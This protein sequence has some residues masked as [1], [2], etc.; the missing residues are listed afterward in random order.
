MAQVMV[1]TMVQVIFVPQPR[2]CSWQ[3]PEHINYIVFLGAYIDI[4]PVSY[5]HLRAHET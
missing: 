1:R 4:A 5:T 3:G 2:L